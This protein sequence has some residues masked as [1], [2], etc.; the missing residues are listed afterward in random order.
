MVDVLS[1]IETNAITTAPHTIQFKDISLTQ[2][3]DAELKQL[4]GSNS[5]LSIKVIQVTTT[6]ITLLCDVSIG[7]PQ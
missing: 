2:K 3:D 4:T 1:H 7:T 5:S 6:D